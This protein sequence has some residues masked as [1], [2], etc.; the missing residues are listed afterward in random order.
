MTEIKERPG[1]VDMFPYRIKNRELF[2]QRDHPEGVHPKS[3]KY[4]QYWGPFMRKCI[5]GYWVFDHKEGEEDKGA[6]FYMTGKMFRYLNYAKINNA[7]KDLVHPDLRTSDIL[8]LYYLEC[9]K[10]FSGFEEDDEYTCHYLI[11]QLEEEGE[12]NPIQERKLPESVKKTD[13]SYKKY[14]HPWHYLTRHYLVE[15][16]KP[17]PLGLALYDNPIKNGMIGSTRGVGKSLC[18]FVAD[19]E[20]EFQFGGVTRWEDRPKVNRRKMYALASAAGPQLK[21]SI[22]AFQNSYIN[23]PGHYKYEDGDGKKKKPDSRGPFYK[24]TQGTWGVG[25]Q[26][27]HVEK[28]GSGKVTRKGASVQMVALTP[29]RLTVA[30]GDRMDIF[31]EE[32]FFLEKLITFHSNIKDTL[33]VDGVQKHRVI[34]LGTGG[35]ITKIKEPMAMFLNPEGYGIFGIPDY[36]HK[37][38]KEMGLFIPKT[39]AV[40][41]A[42]DENGNVDVELAY[43]IVQKERDDLLESSDSVSYNKEIQYNPLTPMEMLQPSGSTKLP[44]KEAQEQLFEI[45]NKGIWQRRAQVGALEYDPSKTRGVRWDKDASLQPI[46]DIDI[47]DAVG[48]KHGAH[49]IYEQ[50]PQYI[51]ENLYWVVYDPAAQAGD[52]ESYHAALVYKYFYSGPGQS[53][54]DCIVGE[55]VGRRMDLDDNYEEVIKLAKY[56]NARIFVEINAPGFVDYCRR[57]D[58]FNLLERDAYLLEKEISPNAKRPPYQ[59]GVRM[60]ARNKIWAM[61]KLP[62]WLMTVKERDANDIPIIRTMDW[63]FS[64]RG[65]REIVSYDPRGNYDVVSCLLI[66]M[67][68]IGKL[69]KE[70]APPESL[71]PPNHDVGEFEYVWTQLGHG[72][73]ERKRVRSKAKI[74]N[75]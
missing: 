11:K 62:T 37:T 25:G 16:P 24:N 19:L 20:H 5:E 26:V 10:G 2:Y 9:T 66:L 7:D 52:G 69:E 21:R 39:Y 47:D 65:L 17:E 30:A 14:V 27:Q 18:V 56:F 70:D 43:D 68:L 29:D 3:Y 48:V 1:L 67:I 41:D 61:N 6:W 46:V 42:R 40:D 60:V 4:K 55:W 22:D 15:H 75:Y 73:K 72:G 58:R 54:Y 32:A 38:G 59:R 28:D 50:P 49:I 53:M 8:L 13:G 34:Y 64:R 36:W 63:F 35:D 45:E 71:D 31:V 44:K 57:T 23:A 33:R 12:L 51:P 74:L